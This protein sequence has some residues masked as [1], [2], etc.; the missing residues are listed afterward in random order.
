METYKLKKYT[1][2]VEKNVMRIIFGNITE[3]SLLSFS[4]SNVFRY[5]LITRL[6]SLVTL[7]SFTF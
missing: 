4:T 6:A 7:L 5:R 3:I 2:N 1:K